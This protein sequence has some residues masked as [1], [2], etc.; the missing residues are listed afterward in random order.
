MFHN[1]ITSG[2]VLVVMERLRKCQT[3]AIDAFEEHFIVEDNDKGIL[4]MCCGSGKT[5]TSYE[6]IKLCTTK[7]EKQIFIIAT[8][9]VNLLYQTMKEFL[10]WKKLD[11]FDISI[12][13]IGGSGE[14]YKN[15]TLYSE[16]EIKCTIESNI[17]NNNPLIIITTYASCDKIVKAIEGCKDLLPDLT[18]LDEAHNTTGE[19]DKQNRGL[20]RKRDSDEEKIFASDKYLFMTATPVKL[21]LKDENSSFSNN[22]TV[23]TMDNEKLYGK[24]IFEYSFYEGINEIVPIL[25]PFETIYYTAD[26]DIPEEIKQAIIG[27]NKNGKQKLY[28]ETISNFTIENIKKY[29]LRHVLIYLPNKTKMKMM[30]KVL[31]RI[32]ND[33]NYKVNSI[34]SDDSKSGRN[35]SLS[36]FRKQTNFSNILLAVG[37]FDEGVDEPCIDTV[38]FAEER[39]TES[40]IVQN[41]GRCLRLHPNKRKS[42]II[43]PNIVY[44][45][46]TDKSMLTTSNTYSSCYKKVRDVLAIV[47]RP[48]TNLFY[49]KYVKGGGPNW[50]DDNVIDELELADEII[51]D[52]SNDT[53]TSEI[54]EDGTPGI[55]MSPYFKQLCTSDSICNESLL[56][57]RQKIK[58]NNI[59]SVRQYG[60]IFKNTP[61]SILHNE[62]KSDWISWSH[63]LY[64]EVAS[65]EEAKCTIQHLSL[66]FTDPSEWVEYYDKLLKSELKN[67]RNGMDDETFNKIIR[68]PNRPKEYFKSDWVD[69]NDFLYLDNDNVKKTLT[70]HTTANIETTADKNMRTLV[71]RD[72]E[73]TAKYNYGEYNDIIITS[74][75]SPIKNYLDRLLKIN[76]Q[77]I[78]RVSIKRNGN[79]HDICM[80]YMRFAKA[81]LVVYP[82]ENKFSYD[83]VNLYNAKEKFT[84]VTKNEHRYF[85][86]KEIDELFQIIIDECKVIVDNSKTTGS[87]RIP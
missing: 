76:C 46:K 44:E 43:I 80:N 74:D 17:S 62:F 20:I 86:S 22:E 56:D 5:R 19:N 14:E 85:Q 36:N 65:F 3:D 87:T 77:L 23:F 66:T 48:T 84:A 54:Q 15:E 69:W 78:V 38:V 83:P 72:G 37:L 11:N 16:N 26:G 1:L 25:T 2:I 51:L 31:E 50:L 82:T 73:K 35:S 81:V 61:Y 33:D 40:R 29:K 79:F 70:I 21:L 68:I 7:Y 63:V 71:N 4:S 55:D 10:H 41:I 47:S 49:K 9:R 24:I 67:E 12:K 52:N 28:Y 18:I 45:F 57:I 6:I 53:T 30:K 32:L 27:M 42:Y 58:E 34:I 39:N 8:S 60:E 64:N 75:L 13:L 59:T